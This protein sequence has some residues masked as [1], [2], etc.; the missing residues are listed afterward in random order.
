MLG[1][2]LFKNV[3]LYLENGNTIA[4]S[5]P[6]N[7]DDN[8]YIGNMKLNGKNYGRNFLTHS[9][10]MSGAKIEYDMVSSPN[11]NR[12][13]GADAKPYSFSREAKEM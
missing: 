8:R 7:S 9:D 1:A 3:R 5:A 10:I 13:V 12:G 11:E 4:L 2:P 6:S